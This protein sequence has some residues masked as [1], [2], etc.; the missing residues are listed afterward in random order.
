MRHKGMPADFFITNKGPM[1]KEQMVFVY[2]YY[3]FSQKPDVAKKLFRELHV[4]ALK[5]EALM[6]EL[7]LD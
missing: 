1:Q 7:N 4:L 6:A 2:Q 3:P 5:T